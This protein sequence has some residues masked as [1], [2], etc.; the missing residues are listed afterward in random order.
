MAITLEQAKIGMADKVTQQVIDEFRRKSVL[1][2]KM[3]FDD[4]VSPGTAGSTLVYGYQRLETPASAEFREINTEYQDQHAVRKLLTA[5]LAVFGGSFA[6][7]R[8][9]AQSSSKSIDEVA[10]QMGEKIKAATNHFHYH[11]IN[12]D[13]AVQE[14]GFDGLN[15]ALKNSIT[16]LNGDSVLD[17]ST[18]EKLEAEKYVLIEAI[19]SMLGELDGRADA[20]LVNNKLKVKLNTLAKITGYYSQSEDAFGRPV[21]N[22][23]SIP[24]VDLGFY[25]GVS[26][27]DSVIKTED[28]TVSTAQTGLT[29][30]YAVRF[31][32]DAFHGAS[33]SGDK[34]IKTYLPD[35]TQPGAVKRG[36]VEFVATPVLKNTRGAGVLRNIKIK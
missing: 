29:D 21:D 36:E 31:G 2:D 34:M 23:G 9:L 32:L 8:V 28:R 3:T 14:H 19:D 5:R 33:I 10:F 1:L 16:E 12:G 22:F 30:I 6:I 20:L 26:S 27:T 17:I 25:A 11:V 4:S 13:T 35:F 7:D 15:K 24:L 18:M